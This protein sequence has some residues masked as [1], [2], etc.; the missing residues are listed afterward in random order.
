MAVLTQLVPGS[1]TLLTGLP[2]DRRRCCRDAQAHS[3]VLSQC[4]RPLLEK[5]QP[6]FLALIINTRLRRESL[7]LMIHRES[8]LGGRCAP[9][10]QELRFGDK[11]AYVLPGL[12]ERTDTG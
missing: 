10:A 12:L 8:V 4:V 1:P 2:G 11:A 7:P 6:F 5:A 3:A 9:A